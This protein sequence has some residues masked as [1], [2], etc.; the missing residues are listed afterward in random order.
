M[1]ADRDF[2]DFSQVPFRL[3]VLLLV[4]GKAKNVVGL[5]SHALIM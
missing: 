1:F 5:S 3:R 4:G 2:A